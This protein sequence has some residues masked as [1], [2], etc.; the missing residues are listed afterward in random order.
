MAYN[1]IRS[2]NHPHTQ[3]QTVHNASA[4]A[5]KGAKVLRLREGTKFPSA[6]GGFKTATSDLAIIANLFQ[7]GEN[8]GIATGH[9]HGGGLVV[10]DFD[11]PVKGQAMELRHMA[12]ALRFTCV[13]ASI[14]GKDAA[15]EIMNMAPRIRTPG[16]GWQ[17]YVR[18][19]AGARLK[20]TDHIDLSAYDLKGEQGLATDGTSFDT[21]GEGGYA[22]APG[23]ATTERSEP[24]GNGTTK[25]KQAAGEY[26]PYWR[27]QLITN[28]DDLPSLSELPTLPAAVIDAIN[29]LPKEGDKGESSQSLPAAGKK[30]K[31]PASPVLAN[32][33]SYVAQSA[34][35]G[36]SM[37]FSYRAPKVPQRVRD[38]LAHSISCATQRYGNRTGWFD[39]M[40]AL[41]GAAAAGEL[42]DEEADAIYEW[43]CT[44]TPGSKSDNADQ[45]KKTKE[46][47]R[48]RLR[49]GED[50]RGC[51]SVIDQALADG[52]IDPAQ[53]PGPA[54]EE[55]KVT[56]GDWPGGAK[57]GRGGR[58]APIDNAVNAAVILKALGFRA[59]FVTRGHFHEVWVPE[60][61]ATP[62]LP[63]GWQD[64][65]DA[66]NRQL[67]SLVI[68]GGI[69]TVKQQTVAQGVKAMGD[70]WKHDPFKE[71]LEDGPAWDGLP[72]IE[73]FPSRYLGVKP[74][75][76]T[77]AWGKHFFMEL[78]ART[79][80]PG[81][82]ADEVLSLFGPQ[83]VGKSTAFRA[84]VGDEFFTDAV[85]LQDT[86][87]E[88]I[89]KTRRA[90][91]VEIAELQ[92]LSG[93]SANKNK[94]MISRQEDRGRLAFSQAPSY[95][96]RAFVMVGTGNDLTPFDDPT[97]ALRFMPVTVGT[98]DVA[99]IERDRDQILAEAMHKFRT[100]FGGDVRRVKLD[101]KWWNKAKE[102][103]EK[104][105]NVDPWEDSISA[106]LV[107]ER[108]RLRV[109]T[110]PNGQQ[111]CLLGSNELLGRLLPPGYNKTG[112]QSQHLAKIMTRLGFVK[113]RPQIDGKREVAYFRPFTSDEIAWR[114]ARA[115]AG[116]L[117]D[118]GQGISLAAGLSAV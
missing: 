29:G 96:G 16:G 33:P 43:F 9:E 8:V 3:V 90:V 14:L 95:A 91:I 86:P 77:A 37:K 107:D 22:V 36:G 69:P 63:S 30:S 52:W 17:I 49:N 41:A 54:I 85:T 62:A 84:L 83:R 65:D 87:Q 45:W 112:A 46:L 105:Q 64:L 47:A 117:V 80:S 57:K 6:K 72:R 13:L 4:L 48:A 99:A 21:R 71:K 7:P 1:I 110:D 68:K 58:L 104:Y 59:R 98:V 20:S 31:A 67:T 100:E 81:C 109:W 94:A 39:T 102:E 70:H 18:A 76:I 118:P 11:T 97:G 5:R 38:A 82:K 92:G 55:A 25:I 60:E 24:H 115:Q 51:K 23:S 106:I 116:Q 61:Q 15:I 44:N 74:D 27:G 42:S 56:P 75:D 40:S 113:H 19:E 10:L 111:G 93:K 88:I 35:E 12:S 53:A 103:T 101:P 26:V 108:G 2:T 34:S 28:L 78:I 89:E 114:N 66:A 50:V 79:Y 73:D 32:A